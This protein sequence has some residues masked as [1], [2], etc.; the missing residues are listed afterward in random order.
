MYESRCTPLRG[1]VPIFALFV[2]YRSVCFVSVGIADF[3]APALNRAR[4]R[5]RGLLLHG[6]RVVLHV[7]HRGGICCAGGFL[8]FQLLL[9]LEE[10]LGAAVQFLGAHLFNMRRDAPA[11][12][13]GIGKATRTVAP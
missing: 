12:T 1:G 3:S 13:K 11:M 4:A 9:L 7:V 5:V 6:F 2:L 8:F 10:Y